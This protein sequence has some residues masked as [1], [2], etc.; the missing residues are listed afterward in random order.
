MRAQYVTSYSPG[1]FCLITISTYS[2]LFS[3]LYGMVHTYVTV[4]EEHPWEA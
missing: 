2:T 3:F 4:H 1:V